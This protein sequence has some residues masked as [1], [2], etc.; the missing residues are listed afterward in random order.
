MR[1]TRDMLFDYLRIHRFNKL[2][3]IH[4]PEK[5]EETRK[6]ARDLENQGFKPL[7]A[8]DYR[9]RGDEAVNRAIAEADISIVL[10]FDPSTVRTAQRQGVTF[11]DLAE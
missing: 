2:Y 8:N 4:E 10:A 6:F 11:I 5:E 7:V 1:F 3:L 9:S